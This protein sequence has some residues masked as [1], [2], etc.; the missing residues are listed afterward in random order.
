M[1]YAKCKSIQNEKYR[2]QTKDSHPLC[3]YTIQ[4]NGNRPNNTAKNDDGVLISWDFFKTKIYSKKDKKWMS[5]EKNKNN[6]EK[7]G[8]SNGNNIQRKLNPMKNAGK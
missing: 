7:K 5:T 6:Q 3:V 2:E 4:R 1:V 8:T